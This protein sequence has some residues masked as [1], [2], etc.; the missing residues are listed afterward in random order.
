MF[1]ISAVAIGII[2]LLLL[3]LAGQSFGQQ[4]LNNNVLVSKPKFAWHNTSAEVTLSVAAE[5]RGPQPYIIITQIID[6]RGYVI[7]IDIEHGSIDSGGQFKNVTM[8][9]YRPVTTSNY[10]IDIFV[11]DDLD[12][13]ILFGVFRYSIDQQFNMTDLNSKSVI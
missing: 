10:F 8:S 6:Q 9:V 4:F 3:P 13:P 5:Y 7:S 2:V 1:T 12:N 11:V